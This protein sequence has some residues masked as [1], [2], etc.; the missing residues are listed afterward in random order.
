MLTRGDCCE[1]S[2]VAP[3]GA[4]WDVLG[5]RLVDSGSRGWR[6]RWNTCRQA[7]DAER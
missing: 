1:A 6:R 3:G 2:F 5:G 7:G 4:S